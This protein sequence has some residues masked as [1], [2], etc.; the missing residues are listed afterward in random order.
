MSRAAPYHYYTYSH[1]PIL[2]LSPRRQLPIRIS[3][4]LLLLQFSC[5]L[6]VFRVYALRSG[7]ENGA[8]WKRV[9]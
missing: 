3:S 1:G 5:S 6:F 2:N 4:Q 7:V 8:A 9:S